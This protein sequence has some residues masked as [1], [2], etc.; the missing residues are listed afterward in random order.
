MK[1]FGVFFL[2]RE[3]RDF[4]FASVVGF[5]GFK[6]RQGFVCEVLRPLRSFSFCFWS[7]LLRFL[8]L[9]YFGVL[10]LIFGFH[11]YFRVFTYQSLSSLK[12]RFQS[13]QS[14]YFILSPKFFKL[15]HVSSFSNF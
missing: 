2:V 7:F 13:L 8:L 14:S 15:L 4:I 11:F 3:G 10:F 12:I 5:D 6:A 1:I 9:F